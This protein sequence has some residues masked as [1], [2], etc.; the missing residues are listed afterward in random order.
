MDLGSIWGG[1]FL[2]FWQALCD[3]EDFREMCVL[4]KENLQ[5]SWLD[6]LIFQDF[7]NFL[8]PEFRSTFGKGFCMY[9]GK[10]SGWICLDLGSLG[11]QKSA[12]ERWWRQ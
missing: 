2:T 9:F 10:V 12:K 7:L 11:H 5:F 1:V 8:R 4:H 3:L 6:D